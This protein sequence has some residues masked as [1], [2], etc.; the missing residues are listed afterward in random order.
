MRSSALPL[1]CSLMLPNALAMCAQSAP[2]HSQAEYKNPHGLAHPNGY[3]QVVVVHG[4]KLVF[5]AGQVALDAEGN[6]VGKG[7]FSAQVTQA[8]A[9]LRTALADAGA[10]PEH[11]VKLNYYVVGLDHDRL[12]AV[13]EARDAVVDRQHPPASTLVGVQSLFREDALIEIEAEAVLP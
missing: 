13:R 8:L 10:K 12:L 11:L 4:G 2:M 7:D 5:I 1:A 9:N 3:S 6:M